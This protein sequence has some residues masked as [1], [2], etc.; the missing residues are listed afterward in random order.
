MSLTI[1]NFSFRISDHQIC[2]NLNLSTDSSLNLIW[3][4]N[5]VGK[6]TFLRMLKEKWGKIEH[7]FSEQEISYMTATSYG[8]LPELTGKEL[9]ELMKISKNVSLQENKIYLSSLFQKCLI[10][11]TKT[12]SNGMKQIFRY[13]LHTFWNPKLLL[14]DEPFQYLDDENTK[15]ICD[16]L[17]QRKLRSCIFLSAQKNEVKKLN[18]DNIIGLPYL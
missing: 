2:S 10:T 6:T 15:L 14:L 11:K 3:G 17:E 7:S 4:K 1:H 8:L 12:F 9:L 18:F 13:Y 5:G 16:D